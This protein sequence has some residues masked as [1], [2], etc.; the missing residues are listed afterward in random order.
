MHALT[1]NR[2]VVMQ[3]A[4]KIRALLLAKMRRF[5]EAV[6]DLQQLQAILGAAAAAGVISQN[7]WLDSAM[8]T[9][10]VLV[11]TSCGSSKMGSLMFDQMS[12]IYKKIRQVT[13]V[14]V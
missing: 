14:V 12:P 13:V 1:V 11:T 8:M 9:L 3:A 7:T 10:L 2:L 4:G 5:Q 6:Q